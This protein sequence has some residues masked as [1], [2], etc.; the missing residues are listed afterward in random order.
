MLKAFR[1]SSNALSGSV[2]QNLLINNAW[3]GCRLYS[4]NT[5]FCQW[6]FVGL[7]FLF[8]D[9]G[10]VLS[11]VQ[12]KPIITMAVWNVSWYLSSTFYDGSDIWF[13]LKMELIHLQIRYSE[14]ES[15]KGM[16]EYKVVNSETKLYNAFSI[17][18]YVEIK[19][20]E[21]KKTIVYILKL[22]VSKAMF[23]RLSQPCGVVL[24]VASVKN[25]SIRLV[26]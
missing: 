4:Y 6:Y 15:I 10:V 19:I 25:T 14:M 22:Y 1:F 11:T 5:E 18:L 21:Q 7:L 17:V 23:I 24:S 26:I 2:L 8:Q 3:T 9:E 16:T 20:F 13:V 12:S